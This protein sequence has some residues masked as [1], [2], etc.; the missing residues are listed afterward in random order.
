MRTYKISYYTEYAD[1]CFDSEAEIEAAG[2][3]D[4]LITFNSKN[5]CK[6]IYKVEELPAMTL[7]RRIELKVN[8]GNDVWTV[9]NRI[10]ESL[11]HN[12]A[13]FNQDILLNK[14]LFAL[15]DQYALAI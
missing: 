9:F 11:T 1:E 6:R 3:Y 13:N 4:A 14:Q 10:Q 15:A 12:V 5:V 2:I 7:E 8:E